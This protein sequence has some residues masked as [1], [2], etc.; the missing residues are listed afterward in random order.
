[1]AHNASLCGRLPG[2]L[3]H[4]RFLLDDGAPA[5]ARMVGHLDGKRYLRLGYF[6]S[7]SFVG[8]NDK[9]RRNPSRTRWFHLSAFPGPQRRSLWRLLK[10]PRQRLRLTTNQATSQ[11]AVACWSMSCAQR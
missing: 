10:E 2:P 7:F 3:G 9:D 4:L 8:V 1:M 6:C 11:A 5:P